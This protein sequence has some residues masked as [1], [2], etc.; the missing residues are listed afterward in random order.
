M[1]RQMS[2]ESDVFYPDA[3]DRQSQRNITFELA[4][5]ES[6]IGIPENFPDWRIDDINP[7]LLKVGIKI[8]STKILMSCHVRKSKNLRVYLA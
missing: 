8:C 6:P 3:N 1:I 5:Q 2:Y 4:N 7:V